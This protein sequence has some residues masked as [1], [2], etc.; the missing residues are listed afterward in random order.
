[1]NS[2]TRK[3]LVRQWQRFSRAIEVLYQQQDD[4]SDMVT[5]GEAINRTPDFNRINTT[6]A[7][8]LRGLVAAGLLKATDQVPDDDRLWEMHPI[9]IETSEDL[10]P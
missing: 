2:A 8:Y 1:M 3:T 7:T 9:N 6:R 10:Y 4:A 5:V